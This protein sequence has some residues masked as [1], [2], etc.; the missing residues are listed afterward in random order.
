MQIFFSWSSSA[1]FPVLAAATALLQQTPNCC[2]AMAALLWNITMG[3][4]LFSHT[5]AV[6]PLDLKEPPLIEGG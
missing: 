1:F 6:W 4:T 2:T 5:G 3:G